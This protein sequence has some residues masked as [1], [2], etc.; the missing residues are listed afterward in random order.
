MLVQRLDQLDTFYYVVPMIRNDRITSL[1]SVDGLYGNFRGGHVLDNP[2]TKP[3]VDRDE[4]IKKVLNGPIDLG[5][6]LGKIV[7]RDGA[8]CFYP[9][10]VWKPCYES[11]SP[12]Y[13]F[14]MISVGGRSIYIGYDGVVYPELHEMGRGA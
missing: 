10:L 3:F 6:Q 4:V 7:I 9:L 14:Y 13:P 2:V 1:F 12:Y 8:Y 11:R 5:E